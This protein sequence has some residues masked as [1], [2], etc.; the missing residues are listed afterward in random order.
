MTSVMFTL[1]KLTQPNIRHIK[2]VIPTA[3]VVYN[4]G[5]D[6]YKSGISRS[7][8]PYI[9]KFLE[10]LDYTWTSEDVWNLGWDLEE[11]LVAKETS[12]GSSAGK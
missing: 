12:S 4:E 6:A 2:D 11:S 5:R 10:E 8:N 3:N 7:S 1:G 9:S